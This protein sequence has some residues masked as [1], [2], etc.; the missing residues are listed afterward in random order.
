V[1]FLSGIEYVEIFVIVCVYLYCHQ[2]SSYQEGQ[3]DPINQFT[4]SFNS[5]G[6]QSEQLPLT[7]IIEHSTT[8]NI[9]NQ[10]PLTSDH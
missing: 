3:V 2:R 9:V 1:V 4:T 8:Y 6:Q 10:S 7:W 5:D